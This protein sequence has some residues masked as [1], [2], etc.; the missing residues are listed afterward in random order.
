V[1]GIN[2]RGNTILYYGNT[3]GYV[4]GDKAVVDPIFEC[5]DLKNDLAD[6]R[7]LQVQW[8]NGVYDRLAK[9]ETVDMSGNM[10][11]LKACRIYQLK[12][13][14]DIRMK[15]IDYDEMVK[16]F[17]EPN[18]EN[19]DV[20]YDG[21]IETNDPGKIFDKFRLERPQGFSGHSPSI[22][23]VIELYDQDG[24]TFFYVGKSKFPQIDFSP[25]EQNQTYSQA[26]NL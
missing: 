23:D 13:D 10:P 2:I 25:P 5:D 11:I 7:G 24:K 16:R 3:A 9:G 22:S 8:I 4:D 19:Y 1:N 21:Q 17:G 6:K 18:P 14:V 12:P 26:M 20:V 15:F